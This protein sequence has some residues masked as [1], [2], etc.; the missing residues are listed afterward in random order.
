MSDPSSYPRY[1]TIAG[2][3][4]EAMTYSRM[5]EHLKLAAECSMV[6]GH[7]RK[8]NG[9]D[10]IAHGFLGIGQLLEQTCTKVTLLATKGIRQ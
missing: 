4:D 1:E 3:A 5:I 7:L 9:E 10:L 6:L 2:Q 8:A